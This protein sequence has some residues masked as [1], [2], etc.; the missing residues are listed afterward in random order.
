MT[1]FT[2][3]LNFGTQNSKRTRRI[4]REFSPCIRSPNVLVVIVSSSA[5]VSDIRFFVSLLSF[6][7]NW[8]K[9]ELRELPRGILLEYSDLKG[10]E[11]TKRPFSSLNVVF[12][13]KFSQKRSSLDWAVASEAESI[14]A[15]TVQRTSPTQT[16]TKAVP[17]I[18]ELCVVDCSCVEYA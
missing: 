18:T 16:S 11:T 15:L 1:V 12:L 17:R 6:L 4:R 9:A 10:R 14:R 2:R 5:M 13:Y 8:D 7:R 3:F